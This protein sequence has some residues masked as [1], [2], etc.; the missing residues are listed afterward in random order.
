M[1]LMMKNPQLRRMMKDA[2]DAP[3][4]STKRSGVKHVVSVLTKLHGVQNEI[5]VA[6]MEPAD[7][8]AHLP[9]YRPTLNYA[10]HAPKPGAKGSYD[11]QG[12][13]PTGRNVIDGQGGPN[14]F[15]NPF[16]IAGP[17]MSAAPPTY[18][19]TAPAPAPAPLPFSSISSSVPPAGAPNMSR[20]PAP[21]ATLP[22]S[23]ITSYV[24][25]AVSQNMTMAPK[26]AQNMSVAPAT[27]NMSVSPDASLAGY[28]SQLENGAA[29]GDVWN[30]A[31][32]KTGLSNDILDSVLNKNKFYKQ[33]ATSSTA[34]GP[35]TQFLQSLPSLPG[36]LLKNQAKTLLGPIGAI[37]DLIKNAPWSSGLAQDVAV[38]AKGA[39]AS[40]ARS[41]AQA[42]N[43]AA[44]KKAQTNQELMPGITKA[45]NDAV[46]GADY[47]GKNAW[48][49][50]TP[51]DLSQTPA[52]K[53]TEGLKQP[54]AW[55]KD[56]TARF[57]GVVSGTKAAAETKMAEVT[58]P[59]DQLAASKKIGAEIG[60]SVVQMKLQAEEAFQKGKSWDEVFKSVRDKV[61]AS[62]SDADI[63]A[64][65]DARWKTAPVAPGLIG[66]VKQPGEV[67]AATPPE[68]QAAAAQKLAA[69]IGDKIG[70]D[71]EIISAADIVANLKGQAEA[72]FAAGK[73]WGEVYWAF[74]NDLPPSVSN[75]DINAFLDEKWK[76]EGPLA[77]AG[78][79][80][81]AGAP[82]PAPAGDGSS[83]SGQYPGI[84]G[85]ISG[86]PGPV[87]GTQGPVIEAPG[88]PG[89]V[90]LGSVT[91]GSSLSEAIDSIPGLSRTAPENINLP[92]AEYTRKVMTALSAIDGEKWNAAF[93]GI[94]QP[95]G[96]SLVGQIDAAIEAKKKDLGL[97][98]L[99]DKKT[100]ALEENPSFIQDSREYI[101]EHDT[102]MKKIDQMLEAAEA[103]PMPRDPEA[104]AMLTGYLSYLNVLKG[105]TAQRYTTYLNKA[106]DLRTKEV[107]KISA[108]VDK[109]QQALQEAIPMIQNKVQEDYSYILG[110]ITANAQKPQLAAQLAVETR[111]DNFKKWQQNQA[112]LDAAVKAKKD[113]EILEPN[114][115]KEKDAV[116]SDVKV[117]GGEGWNRGQLDIAKYMTEF[118]RDPL[119]VIAA[120]QQIMPNAIL[121]KWSEKVVSKASVGGLTSVLDEVNG[122]ENSIMGLN[123]E[124][125]ARI[126]FY[127]ESNPNGNEVPALMQQQS[128]LKDLQLSMSRAN[129]ELFDSELSGGVAIPGSTSAGSAGGAWKALQ[130]ELAKLATKDGKMDSAGRQSWINATAAK[131]TLDPQLLVNIW[132]AIANS[133]PATGD[134]TRYIKGLTAS[135]L[136][137]AAVKYIEFAVSNGQPYKLNTAYSS[138]DGQLT[139]PTQQ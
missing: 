28:K 49:G 84:S 107:D 85:A 37:P 61:P 128:R 36:N 50:P 99:L 137:L 80:G 65:L 66:P 58:K 33:T 74:R 133:G 6:H 89:P 47:T 93:P 132:N 71:G 41:T 63:T 130:P 110:I 30:A 121:K 54:T 72:M 60:D 126:A 13:A 73:D 11:G 115:S 98:D 83:I 62:I 94:P 79:P 39:L 138:A 96:A 20:E 118:K 31:K 16:G 77:P 4:G 101:K 69:A 92:E 29:W 81:K 14:L 56:M 1:E 18:G 125:N 124:L 102:Q 7:P 76:N 2:W 51:T 42:S 117:A 35:L 8:W 64:F 48:K 135:K 103:M 120:M 134:L 86:T 111:D 40:L 25:P 90:N 100:K 34:H 78:A 19:P 106:I 22:F 15:G 9:A 5:G 68:A 3:V 67:F 32:A 24:P 109:A 44:L 70:Q 116:I 21:A 123:N 45:Y 127:K 97:A 27:S 136:S 113:A 114:L 38:G 52:A 91:A 53:M 95:Q 17:N 129:K 88:A 104:R 122:Y 108:D 87:T 43:E 23:S 119:A 82:G 59:E 57:P 46:Y 26:S 131:T 112:V 55:E 105:K 12:G 10:M 75:D 139:A